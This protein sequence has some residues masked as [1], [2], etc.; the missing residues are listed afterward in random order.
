MAGKGDKRRPT[1]EKAFKDNFDKID[2]ANHK[3]SMVEI[4]TPTGVKLVSPK[5][6]EPRKKAHHIMPDIEPY[7]PVGGEG[8]FKEVISSRSKEREY[9]RRNGLIQVGNEKEYFF[10]HNG[11]SDDNPTKNW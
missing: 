6:L 8:A 10:R 9:L 1:D 3:S 2:F 5:S 7:Q 11:K 4:K